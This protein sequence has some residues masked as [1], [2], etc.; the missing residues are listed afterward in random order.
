RVHPHASIAH[1][2]AGQSSPVNPHLG[3][4]ER[5]GRPLGRSAVLAPLGMPEAL[6]PLNFGGAVHHRY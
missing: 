5:C 6:C 3:W 4:P 1:H 2:S